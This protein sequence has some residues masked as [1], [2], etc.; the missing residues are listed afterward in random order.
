MAVQA[1]AAR[2]RTEE[3]VKDAY[4]AALGLK[5]V[6]KGLVDI[7]TD[8]VWF[9]AKAVNT[10]PI[11]M[12]GQLLVYVRAAKKRGEAI[13]GFLAVV[14][15]EKAAIMLTVKALPLLDDKA[16]VWPK[17][18]SAAGKELAVQIAPYV[19][20]HIVEYEIAHD[21]AAFVK[22]LKGAI[23]ERR[24]IRTPITPDS[25]VSIRHMRKVGRELPRATRTRSALKRRA[26]MAG[27]ARCP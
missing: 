20:T 3:D 4:I 27:C 12:F 13:P 24:I 25:C 21:E 22:A 8:E 16:I 26:S 1:G 9:E 14:D 10:P 6:S 5:G 18:G 11:V 7:Q 15:R 19:E 23:K 2:A 17:S